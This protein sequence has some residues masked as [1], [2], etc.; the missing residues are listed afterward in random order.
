MP[1]RSSEQPHCFRC[2]QTFRRLFVV[3]YIK[4]DLGLLPVLLRMVHCASLR[5][6]LLLLLHQLLHK[7]GQQEDLV[8]LLLKVWPL[9]YG[10]AIAHRA[11]DGIMGPR[12][13][14]RDESVA[15]P[16]PAAESV[17]TNSDACG[18]QSKAFTDEI[19]GHQGRSPTRARG[20]G[21]AIPTLAPAPTPPPAPATP[22]E[23]TADLRQECLNYYG[24]D[25]SKCQFH[26]DMLSECR[27]ILPLA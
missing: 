13:V 18:V 11:V 23:S 19:S 14:I 1:R 27:K 4:E 5:R 22:G 12:H 21:R 16:A 2:L 20:R 6:Q 8:L 25:I 17:P 24:S 7:G 9:V 10:S 26:M 15:S 3:I